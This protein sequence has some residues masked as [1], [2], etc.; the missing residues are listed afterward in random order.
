[1]FS[2]NNRM[3]V[4]TIVSRFVSRAGTNVINRVRSNPGKILLVKQA[5]RL[6][7]IVLL[8]SAIS[9]LN[10]RFPEAEIDLLL[11]AKFSDIM[12]DDK[13]INSV[14]PVY[15]KDYISRPWEL[16]KLLKKI[17]KRRY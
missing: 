17:R 7:N 8:N 15:K 2:D 6:G 11:P 3:I 14:I 16:F 10:K 4:P 12:L 5:E 13:R 9:A 1:M